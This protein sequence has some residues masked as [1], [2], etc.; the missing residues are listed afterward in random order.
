MPATTSL[1]TTA[2]GKILYDSPAYTQSV[3]S[4]FPLPPLHTAANPRWQLSF[5]CCR[6]EQGV[7]SCHTTRSRFIRRVFVFPLSTSTS[8]SL[9]LS[10]PLLLYT[11]IAHSALSPSALYPTVCFCFTAFYRSA[12]LALVVATMSVFRRVFSAA[13]VLTHSLTHCALISHCIRILAKNSVHACVKVCANRVASL[14]S[15]SHPFPLISRQPKA[16]GLS[17]CSDISR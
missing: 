17:L 16:A 5:T 6:K 14:A 11:Y 13:R 9:S 2:A 7:R 15:I 1:G 3:P 8:S 4:P 10:L 12:S